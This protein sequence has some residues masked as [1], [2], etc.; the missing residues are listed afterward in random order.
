MGLLAKVFSRL[1]QLTIKTLDVA[2][3]LHKIRGYQDIT[4]VTYHGVFD[5]ALPFNDYC[6]VSVTEFEQQVKYLSEHFEIVSLNEAFNRKNKL[7]K[8][9][10]AVITFDDGFY[11][12]YSVAFPVLKKYQAPA[13]I[14]L[15]TKLINSSSTVW[16]CSLIY[17]LGSTNKQNFTWDNQTFDISDNIKKAQV[18]AQLQAQLKLKQVAALEA[19]LRALAKELGFDDEISYPLTSPFS[20]LNDSAIEEML[21]SGLIEYGAH[22]HN[23]AILSNLNAENAEAELTVSIDKITDITGKPCR[24]F[25]Y[26]N[27]RKQD[28]QEEHKR[29]LHEKGIEFAASTINGL[30]SEQDDPLAFKRL[31]INTGTD[32]PTFKL[33]V[34]GFR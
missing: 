28:F 34:H 2:P 1:K 17:M 24:Y 14:F 26:P 31:F 12:N 21:A 5:Q 23:H 7:N 4:V 20:M 25:A 11:N 9:P 33:Q 10:L 15:A 18:S 30:T 3:Q 22:T 27:G 29:M 6:F 32:L 8:K 16:F 19:T 13:I